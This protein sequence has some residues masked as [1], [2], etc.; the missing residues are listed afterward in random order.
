MLFKFDFA[1]GVSSSEPPLL[2]LR[3]FQSLRTERTGSPLS[4]VVIFLTFYFLVLLLASALIFIPFPS[5]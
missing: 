1:L 4:P 5:S 3:I 2:P